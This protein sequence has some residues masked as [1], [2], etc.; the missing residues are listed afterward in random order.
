MPQ[1][2]ILIMRNKLG[3][4]N[5]LVVKLFFGFAATQAQIQSPSIQIGVTFNWDDAA[6]TALQD[7]NL[8]HYFTASSGLGP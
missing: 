2:K 6:I 8:N 7:L 1:V 5:L 3:I 4:S